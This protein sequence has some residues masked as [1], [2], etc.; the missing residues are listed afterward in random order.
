MHNPRI[1]HWM[2]EMKVK[3]GQGLGKWNQG[4]TKPITV[5]TKLRKQGLGY[6]EK[7][8]KIGQDTPAKKWSISKKVTQAH[9]NMIDFN[10]SEV[11]TDEPKP[12]FT[13]DN[14]VEKWVQQLTRSGRAY[15]P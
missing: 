15:Q 13:K 12:K 8:M 1:S 2:R 14:E 11:A 3:P 5:Q 9:I 10:W 7:K 4:I 6:Q